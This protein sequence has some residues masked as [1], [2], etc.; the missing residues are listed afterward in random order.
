VERAGWH[1]QVPIGK[2]LA[3]AIVRNPYDNLRGI[4]KEPFHAAYHGDMKFTAFL[5]TTWTL[6]HR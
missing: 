1:T 3:I 5:N 6:P 4:Y 2:K